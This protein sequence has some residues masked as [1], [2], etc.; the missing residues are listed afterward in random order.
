MTRRAARVGVIGLTATALSCAAGPGVHT[1]EAAQRIE[2]TVAPVPTSE[3]TP[4][5]TLA[6]S[7]CPD[8]HP[9]LSMRWEC[10][11][12][13]TPLD[14]ADPA[15]EE[16]AVALTR[17]VL[18]P[19]DD[20]RPLVMNPGGPGASG[21]ELAWYLA[22]LLPPELLDTYYPV[23]WDPRGVGRSVP[24]ID[25]G[26]F[27]PID[28]PDADECI[29][30]S[31][32]LL[33]QVG[34]ADAALDLESVRDAVGVDRLDYLGF[35]YGTALGAVYAMA[36]PDRVGRFVLDGSI[37]PTAG[38]PA[39]ELAA[40]GVPDY[41]GDEID[42][43]IGRF[44][45]LCDASALCAA[46]PDSKALVDD[47]EGSIRDLTTADFPGGPSRL[48]R[49]DLED[50][51][52]GI[53]YDPWSWGLVGDALRDAADG[54]ASTLAALASYLLQG[55]P[56]QDLPGDDPLVDFGA[57]HLAI[58]CADFS[59]IEGVWGCD[60]MPDADPLPV[61]TAVD[62]AEPIV[63]VGTAHDPSTPGRHAIEMA[64]A[65]GDAVAITWDGVGHTAF[66]VTPCLDDAVVAYLVDGVVPDQ[67]LVCPFM[68]GMPTDGEIGDH[69]FDYQ[70]S[71]VR[72]WL[73]DVLV[74]EGAGGDGRCLAR[75]LA[76]AD[77]RV[78]THLLLG[79]QSPAANEATAAAEAAC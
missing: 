31:G 9:G 58:Y 79:V 71:W 7:A 6:W 14:H 44:H 33:A 21:V 13:A 30:S 42:A 11:T 73:E 24:A 28:V 55:Y 26:P 45:E 50:V 4:S 3:P 12:V 66:P 64:G 32:A 27:D 18:E 29:A 2:D 49:L 54:N 34:A 63:V 75:E 77:H 20:R 48:N 62:V 22:D 65:L 15:S 40:D 53:T 61:I 16:I 5:S 52:I 38:D 51:M 35:S 10:T 46:G 68:D 17:P 41:A 78:L 8:L 76:G 39:G 37:D 60:G 43:A 67:G 25:C 57:A 72:P 1:Q 70:S 36:H 23:G 74:A 19:G 69:L 59:H 47:L 56:V